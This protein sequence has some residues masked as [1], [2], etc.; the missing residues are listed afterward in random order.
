MAY[1]PDNRPRLEKATR[2][3]AR[4]ESFTL[5]C[6]ACGLVYQIRMGVKQQCWD[7]TT[8]LFS[9]TAKGG[10]NK[11]YVIGLVAWPVS[12]RAWIKGQPRDQVPH[13]RQLAQLRKEGGGWWL[14][15]EERQR[16]ETVHE[17][18]LTT[19]QDRPKTEDEDE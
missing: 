4:P 7:H 2:F 5:E 11:V 17:S 6:P 9:C 19:E 15:D 14:P 16:Y 8:S 12:P 3:F 13:V 18:N 1:T 10:C